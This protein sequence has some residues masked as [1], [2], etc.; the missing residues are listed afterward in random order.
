MSR[1]HPASYNNPEIDLRARTLQ[2][3]VRGI[4][5]LRSTLQRRFGLIQ[6]FADWVLQ[7]C[8]AQARCQVTDTLR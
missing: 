2:K 6:M 5:S 8:I 4:Q 1:I 3:F 7:V